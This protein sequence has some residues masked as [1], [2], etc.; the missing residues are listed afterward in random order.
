[1]AQL[2]HDEDIFMLSL[3][4]ETNELHTHNFLELVYVTEG[5]GIHTLNGKETLVQKGDYFIID[6]NSEHKYAAFKNCDFYITN[7]CFKPKFIDRALSNCTSFKEVINSYQI[8]L[9]YESTVNPTQHVFHDD[10]SVLPLIEKLT[11]EYDE[12]GA[13][14]LELMRCYLIE[15]LIKTMRTLSISNSSEFSPIVERIINE[16]ETNYSS[17][18]SLSAIAKELNYSMPYLSSKFFSETGTTFTE[19]LQSTRIKQSCILMADKRKRIIDIA[20]QV[21]YKDIKFF[22]SIFKKYMHITPKQYRKSAYIAF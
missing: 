10:K 20:E 15:I 14:Y 19:F 1:M 13:G 18:L 22:N 12:K 17:P 3:N 5:K 9:K 2:F 7:C 6:F 21:G 4:Q 8:H 16:I 11:C